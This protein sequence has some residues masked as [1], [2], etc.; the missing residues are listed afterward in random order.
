VI[1]VQ[2]LVTR[3]QHKALIDEAYILGIPLRDHIKNILEDHLEKK[4]GN[5]NDRSGS[6]NPKE[7]KTT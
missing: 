6:S 2:A 7:I 5:N 1:N 3:E 4:K